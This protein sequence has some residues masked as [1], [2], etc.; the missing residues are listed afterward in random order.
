MMEMG[1]PD[2][3]Q[4]SNTIS[5]FEDSP[6][7][8]YLNSLS[9]IKPD[10]S[11]HV[12]QPFSSLTFALLPSI[13]ASPQV[14]SHKESRFL[15]RSQELD[16]ENAKDQSENESK[17]AAVNFANNTTGQN[18][19]G[20]ELPGK[21]YVTINAG[22][23]SIS[24]AD[25]I[26]LSQTLKYDSGSPDCNSTS[27]KENAECHPPDGLHL[28]QHSED[29]ESKE[30]G[31]AEGISGQNRELMQF[32]LDG[33]DLKS[34]DLLIFSSPNDA[35][36]FRGLVQ[37]SPDT[38]NGLLASMVPNA[39]QHEMLTASENR[40]LLLHQASAVEQYETEGHS[41][42]SSES[43][44]S[45][46]D[47]QTEMDECFDKGK[48]GDTKALVPYGSKMSA[49]LHRGI[50]RRC[51]DF[52][53]TQPNQKICDSSL[54]VQQV[55]DNKESKDKRLILVKQGVTTEKRILPGIGLHLNALTSS[56][57]TFKHETMLP[58]PSSQLSTADQDNLNP[59]NSENEVDPTVKSLPLMEYDPTCASMNYEE[60]NQLSPRKKRHRDL[61]GE[62]ESCKRCNCKK[63]KC[64]KLYCECFAAGVYCIEP[65]AC[66]DCL[67]KPIHEETVLATRKQIES[68]N[69]LAFAPKVIRSSDT[70]A[71][72]W[73]E[74]NK[75]PA[76]A[77]HK[78]GCNCKKSNCLK[79]YCECYQEG[80]GCSINCRCEGCKNAFGTKDGTILAGADCEMEED[81]ENCEKSAVA[82]KN[83]ELNDSLLLSTPSELNRPVLP[84]GFPPKAKQLRSSLV[85]SSYS[86]RPYQRTGGSGLLGPGLKARQTNPEDEIPRHT[87]WRCS[88]HW[89]NEGR[90]SYQQEGL[91]SS[92]GLWFYTGSTEW[93]PEADLEID[94]GFPFTLL[95]QP[96]VNSL[97]ENASRPSFG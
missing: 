66:Q 56:S 15:K 50:R 13:F 46:G 18:E 65:C 71:E 2:K 10:K 38:S 49:D 68:R 79:K 96:G 95:A 55:T 88:H 69:P 17:V 31:D 81:S 42:L 9:P 34:T 12:A 26:E 16:L 72:T 85:S 61:S 97:F 73:D 60:L 53:P 75:T 91:S 29:H 25:V 19:N 37:I 30:K 94:S 57:K 6:V 77:R 93:R 82:Q 76:S 70:V 86:I 52:E 24:P 87:L 27:P 7:F 43:H 44:F 89:P 20:T 47:A 8:N 92:C 5:H 78:R 28:L 23:T 67:N 74:I 63:S 40:R 33:L 39:A 32:S 84:M 62:P 11:T 1:T 35:S 45:N 4:I 83:M 48:G 54:A 59:V 14:N 64:L 51:L 41:F 80:V 21:F 22:E 36:A 90:L 3:T 58:D